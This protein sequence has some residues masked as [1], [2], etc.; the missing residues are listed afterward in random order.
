MLDSLLKSTYKQINR[1]LLHTCFEKILKSPSIGLCSEVNIDPMLTS[2]LK[3]LTRRFFCTNTSESGQSVI[4]QVVPDCNTFYFNQLKREGFHALTAFSLSL[5]PGAYLIHKGL[6][7]EK[8]RYFFAAALVVGIPGAWYRYWLMKKNIFPS[9][10]VY[11][12]ATNTITFK[13]MSWLP[14]R[15]TKLVY[16]PKDILPYSRMPH[17]LSEELSMIPKFARLNPKIIISPTETT[18]QITKV[19]VLVG[20]I[21]NSSLFQK[22]VLGEL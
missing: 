19:Y 5:V 20:G 10:V 16:S 15:A 11:E 21:R 14:W 6:E 4:F 13:T 17:S 8:L 2:P 9:K 1:F 22:L 3:A 12:A 7:K 18:N